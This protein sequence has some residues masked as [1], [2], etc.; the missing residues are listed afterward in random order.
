MLNIPR[1]RI[2]Q[3]ERREWCNLLSCDSGEQA[4]R[5]DNE[6]WLLK[7]AINAA[8]MP[9]SVF[10]E[11]RQFRRNSQPAGALL[12]DRISTD[13]LQLR[14]TP[15]RYGAFQKFASPEA[16]ALIAVGSILG[17]PIGYVEE[18]SGSLIHDIVPVPGYETTQSNAGSDEFDLHVENAFHDHRPDFV[19]LL[20]VRE[21]HRREAGLRL[22]PLRRALGLLRDSTVA[23]LFES[24][25]R[26]AAPASFVA[27]HETP[28]HPVLS[29]ALDDP[30]IRADMSVTTGV[31]NVA[32][33]A[34]AELWSVLGSITS[35][36]KLKSGQ[37]AIVDNRVTLHG[38]TGFTPQFDG[39]DRWLLRLFVKSDLRPSRSLRNGDARQVSSA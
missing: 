36:E 6:E 14:P 31:D 19:L 37:I 26:T 2:N 13:H 12:I 11:I 35:V 21:D 39:A 38:R 25:F 23:T 34:L 4:V 17:E 5:I 16:A 8:R 30:D 3:A 9:V 33:A 18:K 7:Q 24:R 20:C 27:S 28:A 1:I 29:G 22:A 32:S 10:S 15:D